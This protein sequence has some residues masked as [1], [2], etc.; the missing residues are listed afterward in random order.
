M[1]ALVASMVLFMIFWWKDIQLAEKI[2]EKQ[3]RIR[4][5]DVAI[6]AREQTLN[7]EL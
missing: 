1:H 3:R 7:P 6:K 5:L 4:E 2:L